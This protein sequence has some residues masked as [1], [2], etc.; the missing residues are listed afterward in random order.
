MAEFAENTHFYKKKVFWR[1]ISHG[2][3]AEI[4][5]SLKMSGAD[6]SSLSGNNAGPNP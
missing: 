6:F 1:E 4:L 3:S 2:G 5:A